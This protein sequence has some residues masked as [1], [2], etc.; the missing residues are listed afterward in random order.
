MYI[1]AQV[2]TGPRQ[3]DLMTLGNLAIIVMSCTAIVKYAQEVA[4]EQGANMR[5]SI[6]RHTVW[7]RWIAD[8]FHRQPDSEHNDSQSQYPGGVEWS[9]HRAEQPIMIQNSADQ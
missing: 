4:L 3:D 5:L 6:W 2:S 8:L 9:Y 1:P 7:M